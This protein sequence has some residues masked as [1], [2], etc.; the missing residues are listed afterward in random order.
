[1]SITWIS[2]S[3]R[4]PDDM[5]DVMTRGRYGEHGACF[6]WGTNDDPCWWSPEVQVADFKQ[7]VTHWAEMPDRPE[8]VLL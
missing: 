2:V 5:R 4:Y 8:G 3:E 6:E 1:M 7:S